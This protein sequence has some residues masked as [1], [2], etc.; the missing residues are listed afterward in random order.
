M[1]KATVQHY[2]SSYAS[3]I[4]F[5]YA[6]PNE[7]LVNNMDRLP[8]QKYL[9]LPAAE[10]V[11]PEDKVMLQPAG[12]NLNQVQ[13]TISVEDLYLQQAKESVGG[14]VELGAEPLE[15]QQVIL[16]EEVTPIE[17]NNAAPIVTADKKVSEVLLKKE[18][19]ARVTVQESY[20]SSAE[21]ELSARFYIIGG[22]FR[23]EANAEKLLNK[24]RQ[25][26]YSSVYAGRTKT[27]LLRVSYV[28]LNDR[29]EALSVLE[30]IQ[31][32]EDQ[33]AWLMSM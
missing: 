2:Y 20:G 25:K 16:A 15:K 30:K 10:K 8:V 4:P 26:G 27:G 14:S 17:D 28:A 21:E 24:L 3:L 22:A 33:G 31:K 11:T 23:D 29:M 19:P 9:P 5:F 6:S 13:N 7:Y 18:S 12:N 1:N 32:E